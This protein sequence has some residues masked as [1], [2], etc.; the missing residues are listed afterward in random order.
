M[1]RRHLTPFVS[2]SLLLFLPILAGCGGGRAIPAPGQVWC[3]G[4]TELSIETESLDEQARPAV[5][6]RVKGA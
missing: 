1:N 3:K 4:E 5:W 6:A 2:L